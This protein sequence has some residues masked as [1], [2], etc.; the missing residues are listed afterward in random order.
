MYL[1][2][3]NPRKSAKYEFDE[4]TMS[5]LGDTINTDAMHLRNG[6]RAKADEGGREGM[7]HD[8][9]KPVTTFP[10]GVHDVSNTAHPTTSS[11]ANGNLR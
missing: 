11:G 9:G 7:F 4:E 6:G 5:A 1:L 3:V 8:E 10:A 2:H